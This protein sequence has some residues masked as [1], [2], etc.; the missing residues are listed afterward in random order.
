[1]GLLVYGFIVL[2]F[3][4]I[5]W[6]HRRLKA[7]RRKRVK[8]AYDFNP[9]QTQAAGGFASD[10]DLKRGG[11][12]GS[13][14]I[15]IGFSRDGKALRYGG[16]GH[17]ALVAAAR[18]G[19]LFTILCTLIFS[20]PK[21]YSLLLVDPKAEITCIVGAARKKHAAPS[22]PGIPTKSGSITWRACVRCA[23]T[24]WPISTRAR[25]RWRPTAPS[26]SRHSG[27]KRRRRT[28][29]RIG[30]RPEKLFSR[31]IVQAL[32]KYGKPD[33]KNLPTARN[34]LT[35]AQR[36]GRSSNSRGGS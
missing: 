20:L 33:E 23:S 29:I 11:L 22:M 16:A 17:L 27:M 15:R 4:A 13:K 36:A 21:K 25:S 26:S 10:D 12:F 8:D 3:G 7:Q 18:T 19:K 34:V 24:P 5:G 1:M 32:V 2:V 35:G 31:R 14:G 28:T 6:E 30:G 9:K